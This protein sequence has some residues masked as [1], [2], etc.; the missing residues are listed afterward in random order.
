MLN[1]VDRIAISL[2]PAKSQVYYYALDKVDTSVAVDNSWVWI[3]NW[4]QECSATSDRSGT[5]SYLIA[6]NR[7]LM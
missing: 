7:S 5:V 4:H 6:A 1:L 2:G 3:K